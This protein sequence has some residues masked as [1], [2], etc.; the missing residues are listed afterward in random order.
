MTKLTAL[1][2]YILTDTVLHSISQDNYWTGSSTKKGRE[3]VLKKLQMIMNEME[4][5]LTVEKTD[6]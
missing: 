6:A 4:V 5:E 1:D 3:E 2:L